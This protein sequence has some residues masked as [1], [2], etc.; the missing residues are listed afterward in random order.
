VLALYAPG[1]NSLAAAFF[2]PETRRLQVLEDTK[3][4]WGWDLAVLCQFL[5]TALHQLTRSGGAVP[6]LR[7]YPLRSCARLPRQADGGTL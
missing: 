2:D 1:Q 7:A 3:D 4:T 5:M 6:A